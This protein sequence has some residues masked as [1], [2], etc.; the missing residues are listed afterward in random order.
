[1]RYAEGNNVATSVGFYYMANAGLAYCR[2]QNM[3][4]LKDSLSLVAD[5]LGSTA[6]ISHQE[7]HL[8]CLF[9]KDLRLIFSRQFSKYLTST[10]RVLE[11]N[12]CTCTGGRLMGTLVSGALYSY[13]DPVFATNGMGA[14][15]LAGATASLV[16]TLATYPICDDVGGRCNSS[17]G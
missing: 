7:L 9:P 1:M 5:I 4:L 15:F 3:S 10:P 8:C 13:V 16:A 2:L 14:C 17:G 12:F 6:R 11:H